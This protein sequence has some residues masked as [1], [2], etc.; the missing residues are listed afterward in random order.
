MAPAGLGGRHCVGTC[1]VVTLIS[2]WSHR[3]LGLLVV[4]QPPQLLGFP[5]TAVV[6]PCNTG[7]TRA[8]PGCATSL[9]VRAGGAACALGWGGR[10]WGWG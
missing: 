10:S 6:S 1:P 4:E 9:G 7:T 8:A 5:G 2:E 3:R